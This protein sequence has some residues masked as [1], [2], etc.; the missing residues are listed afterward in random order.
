MLRGYWPN[1]L[2]KYGG[3]MSEEYGNMADGMH[4]SS[5]QTSLK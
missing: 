5:S 3:K 2:I 4:E 1:K